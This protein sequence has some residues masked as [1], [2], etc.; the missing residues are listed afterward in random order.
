MKIQNILLT[1]YYARIL[2]PGITINFRDL[3]PG[4]R[5]YTSEERKILNVLSNEEI[6]PYSAAQL[7]AS[8]S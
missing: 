5:F 6:V 3:K 8:H 2:T 1:T 4:V 7:R